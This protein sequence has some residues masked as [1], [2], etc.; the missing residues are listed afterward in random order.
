M[1]IWRLAS[2][3]LREPGRLMELKRFI[4][5]DRLGRDVVLWKRRETAKPGLGLLP[6]GMQP[7]VRELFE[8]PDPVFVL[9]D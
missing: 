1:A 3:G 6:F 5:V 9:L 2:G 7:L 4:Y 8:M